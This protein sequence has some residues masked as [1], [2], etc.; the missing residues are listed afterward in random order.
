[1][2]MTPFWEMLSRSVT[3]ASC[4]LVPNLLSAPHVIIVKINRAILALVKANDIKRQ[5]SL[6]EEKGRGY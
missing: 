1:M 3:L 2:K 5:V 4:G 6:R